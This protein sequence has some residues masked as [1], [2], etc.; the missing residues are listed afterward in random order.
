MV[1]IVKLSSWIKR[2]LLSI[3]SGINGETPHCVVANVLDC[4]IVV[5]LSK[6]QSRSYVQ[7]R[8]NTLGIGVN[9]FTFPLWI[10]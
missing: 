3:F 7:F 2:N 4:N 5:S 6:R 10:K 9:F 8:T 1:Q